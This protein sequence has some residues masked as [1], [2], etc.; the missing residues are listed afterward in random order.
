[1]EDKV[2]AVFH[3]YDGETLDALA[4]AEKK[5]LE[6]AGFTIDKEKKAVG[7]RTFEVSKGNTTAKVNVACVPAKKQCFVSLPKL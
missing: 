5:L 6:G 4:D 1:M 7:Y 3:Y 2:N